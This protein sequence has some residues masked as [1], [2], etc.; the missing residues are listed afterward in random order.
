[1]ADDAERAEE[2]AKTAAPLEV[3][4]GL[5][6]W[7]VQM[8]EEGFPNSIL[9]EPE[10]VHQLELNRIRSG[11]VGARGKDRSQAPFPAR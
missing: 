9:S 7:V 11:M 6:G 8:E 10:S 4:A 2:V 1:M 5:V 3:M